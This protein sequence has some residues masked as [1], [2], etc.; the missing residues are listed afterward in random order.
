MICPLFA[1][2]LPIAL[3]PDGEDLSGSGSGTPSEVRDINH[4]DPS[5]M[6]DSQD[7]LNR[8]TDSLRMLC[9]W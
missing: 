4:I 3:F 5:L 1:G 9:E 6:E 8:L 2:G 7:V